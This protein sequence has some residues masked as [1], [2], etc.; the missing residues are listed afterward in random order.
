MADVIFVLV[1]GSRAGKSASRRG[2]GGA[3]VVDA[4]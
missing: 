4:Q 1:G 2:R 3:G